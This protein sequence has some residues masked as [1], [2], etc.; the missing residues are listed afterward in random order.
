MGEGKKENKKKK[1]NVKE[2]NDG[3]FE[4]FVRMTLGVRDL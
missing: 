2:E 4:C 3:R 1:K